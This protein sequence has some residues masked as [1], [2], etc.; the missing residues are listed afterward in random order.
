MKQAGGKE[1]MKAKFTFERNGSFTQLDYSTSDSFLYSKKGEWKFSDK[2][3]NL[4]IRWMLD[5]TEGFYYVDNNGNVVPY[6]D[7]GQIQIN[8][9][10]ETKFKIYRLTMKELWIGDEAGIEFKCKKE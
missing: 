6:A 9:I 1:S 10:N 7:S 3:E 2:K 8:G 4:T 5:R